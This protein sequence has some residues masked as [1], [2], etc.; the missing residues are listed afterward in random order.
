MPYD[1]GAFVGEWRQLTDCGSAGQAEL[2]VVVASPASEDVTVIVVVQ[3]AGP[4]D[5]AVLEVIL[6]SFNFTPTATWPATSTTDLAT[7]T[8]SRRR[9]RRRRSLRT[10]VIG[11]GGDVL[12]ENNSGV[13]SVQAPDD[14]A[15]AD[16]DGGV[17]NDGS[18]RPTIAAAP[19]L[20]EFAS[21]FEYPGLRPPRPA[22]GHRS[23]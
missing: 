14:W 23:S 11:A 10:D 18:Y 7:T 20:E 4:Q 19:S 9:R 2:H 1:D 13:L 21:G 3:L 12:V 15:D 17:N 22:S 8:S 6:Q 5:Q 16:T